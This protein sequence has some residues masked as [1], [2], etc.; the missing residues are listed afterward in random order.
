MLLHGLYI[1]HKILCSHLMLEV[2]VPITLCVRLIHWC[3]WGNSAQNVVFVFSGHTVAHRSLQSEDTGY[4]C[5]FYWACIFYKRIFLE[6]IICSVA[7]LNPCFALITV[8]AELK[9]MKDLKL[10]ERNRVISV[11]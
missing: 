8:R 2:K 4:K 10:I 3:W 9:D 1:A 5:L 7:E 11:L 6:V